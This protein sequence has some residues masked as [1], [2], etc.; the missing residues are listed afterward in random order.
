M[1]RK[2]QVSIYQDGILAR[3]YKIS[4]TS[5]AAA[6]DIDTGLP[7]TIGQ[8]PTGL[9]QETG[10]GEMDDLG[11]WRR[12]LTPLEAASIYTAGANGQSFADLPPLGSANLRI[13]ASGPT[14]Q[15]LWDQGILQQA[16]TLTG[17]WT[18]VGAPVT[19]PHTTTPIETK[20]Y[21]MKP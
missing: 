3:A 18:D 2:S 11:V 7:A 10:A 12:A 15:I 4:G 1:D 14:V 5:T 6:T 8:D 9:Y 21:R 17:P 19:S 16:G 13:T 20:F